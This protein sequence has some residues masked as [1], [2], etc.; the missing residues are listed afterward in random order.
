MLEQSH[1]C[2]H[3]TYASDHTLHVPAHGQPKTEAIHISNHS[4]QF[5]SKKRVTYAATERSLHAIL[6]LLKLLA[7]EA[8]SPPAISILADL[9]SA[10]DAA[11]ASVSSLVTIA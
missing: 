7:S 1:F 8:A 3:C 6:T 11:S 9:S 10:A 4:A 5:L 2:R